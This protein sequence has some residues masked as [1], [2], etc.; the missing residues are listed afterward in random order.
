MSMPRFRKASVIGLSLVLSL[1]ATQ[2]MALAPSWVL[3]GPFG[4]GGIAT[5]IATDAHSPGTVY[6]GT[7]NGVFRTID[8]GTTWTVLN[9][10]LTDVSVKEFSVEPIDRATIYALTSSGTLFRSTNQD[11][12]APIVRGQ[13]GRPGVATVTAGASAIYIGTRYPGAVYQSLDRGDTWQLLGVLSGFQ[14]NS[15]AVNGN[16]VLAATDGGVFRSEDSGDT[17]APSNEGLGTSVATRIRIDPY[18][19]GVVWAVTPNFVGN[20]LF[21]SMDGGRHWAAVTG[22]PTA[23]VY[24]FVSSSPSSKYVALGTV[25]K[26]ADGG[27]S[28]VQAGDP[29]ASGYGLTGLAVALA[30]DPTQGE[31]LYAAME[32]DVGGGVAKS[33]NGGTSWVKLEANSHGLSVRHITVDP[34]TPSLIYACTEEGLYKSVDAAETWTPI[35][36]SLPV[37]VFDL[38]IDTDALGTIYVLAGATGGIFRSEDQSASWASIGNGLP[39]G[40]PVSAI[41]VDQVVPRTLYVGVSNSGVYRSG[42]GGNHWDAELTSSSVVSLAIDPNEHQRV[43]AATGAGEIYGSSNGGASWS[44]L[45]TFQS[46]QS[47][48]LL[49]VDTSST[50]FA[51][52]EY[53]GVAIPEATPIGGIVRSTDDGASWASA[54]R[55]LPGT[56]I[57]SL[58]LDGE[59]RIYCT[60]LYGQL[61]RSLDHGS[62]WSRVDVSSFPDWAVWGATFDPTDP[63]QLYA[64]VAWDVAVGGVIRLTLGPERSSLTTCRTAGC[65]FR[66]SR[67]PV[68]QRSAN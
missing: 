30:V 61:F 57:G 68:G 59:G 51:S 47:I 4:K 10:G 62:S 20:G 35:G 21:R 13:L 67:R 40:Q 55:G 18:S 56:A 49:V 5:S 32:F 25:Y 2:C 22:L 12:W 14:V 17:W 53:S 38:R 52:W 16:V 27:A 19:P 3:N 15:I 7:E 48:Q 44:R 58:A 65:P 66:P 28:W 24:D 43:Y 50:V 41:V 23:L 42:D 6:V 26:S 45:Y 29:K 64:A 31:T 34:K 46:Y 33:S 37:P 54:N 1:L 39:L 9:Q 11:S 8:E 63:S 60:P 36:G